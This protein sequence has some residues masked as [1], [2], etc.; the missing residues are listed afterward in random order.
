[1]KRIYKA[2]IIIAVLILIANCSPISDQSEIL[3]DTPVQ[4]K[5]EKENTIKPTDKCGDGICDKAEQE[6]GICP[7]DCP[8]ESQNEV[9]NEDQIDYEQISE[10]QLCR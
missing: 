5:P 2:L 7:V 4:K 10:M 1:M 8:A 6:K 3:P 9:L